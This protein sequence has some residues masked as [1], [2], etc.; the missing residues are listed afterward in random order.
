MSDTAADLPSWPRLK[1][2][3]DGG[4]PFVFFV[5]YGTF[6]P[7][8]VYRSK[9]RCAGLPDGVVA[10]KYHDDQLPEVRDQFRQGPAWDEFTAANPGLADTVSRA[11][12][13]LVLK[14]EVADTDSLNYLRDIIGFITS[15]M[16]QG[17]ICVCDPQMQEWW[18]PRSWRTR[19]FDVNEAAPRQHVVVR[20]SEDTNPEKYWV[21]TRGMRLFGRPDL[22]MHDV[23][24]KNRDAALDMVERF[25]ELQAFG[26]VVPE[27]KEIAMNSLPAGMKC[28]HR[29]HVDAPEF[30]NVHIEIEWP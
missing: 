15:M 18:S 8:Y 16:D 22:S 9:Y 24:K 13:G 17:C 27:G 1:Y 10:Q 7:P 21:H 5:L 14:G 29:G 28:Y 12:E 19:I 4:K 20:F 6:E 3:S 11:T 25:I 26:G 30:N 2:E 23:P